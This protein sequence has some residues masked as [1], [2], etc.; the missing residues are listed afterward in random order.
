MYTEPNP[1]FI[2]IPF[3]L[4]PKAE[5]LLVLMTGNLQVFTWAKWV[6][7]EERAWELFSALRVLRARSRGRE[8][9][10]CISPP[11]SLYALDS[12]CKQPG[13]CILSQIW[14]ER[15]DQTRCSFSPETFCCG[16]EKKKKE[17]GGGENRRGGKGLRNPGEYTHV[18]LREQHRDR[19]CY[20]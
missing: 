3:L 4:I 15:V 13:W 16:Q 5:F 18:T 9:Q 20:L 17:I 6:K 1:V 10:G 11:R 19:Y 14:S 8:A 7:K 2:L 12:S